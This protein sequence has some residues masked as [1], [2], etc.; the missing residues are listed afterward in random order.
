MNS[1]EKKLIKF[2][3]KSRE[4]T[5]FKKRNRI[6]D[7]VKIAPEY[8]ACSFGNKNQNKLFYVI[9]RYHGGGFFSNFLF[10]LNHLIQADKLNA[11]P[12]V[13]MENFTNVYSERK[14]INGTY[15]SWLYY[16][17]QVSPY[18]L[19]E[20]YKSKRVIFSSEKIF[21]E[22]SV[23]AKE[24]EGEL[25]KV[26]K[27]YINIKKEFLIIANKFIK[28]NFFNKKILGVHWRGTD[29]KVLPS[30][31]FPPTEKQI[32][33]ITD[34]LMSGKKF[35]MI[36]LVTEEKRYLEIFKKNYGSKVC[37]FNSFRS[38]T[39]EQFSKNS[40]TNHRY[41]LGKES[42]IE[43]L[44]LSNLSSLVC[45]RS[46]IS[47][48]AKFLSNNKKFKIYEIMNGFNSSSILHSLYMWHLKKILPKFLGGFK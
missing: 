12:V 7:K 16:F 6:F 30:H 48:Q 4:K 42:L 46:N 2:F 33:K 41:N 22:Q 21:F 36:F 14:K 31:P 47:E 1:L 43:V 3:L 26:Y 38:N 37:Y 44:I 34:K 8:K 18:T 27:K 35:N 19:V 20:V 13:D 25:K 40:R 24:N 32:L 11:I 15:N 10:V 5:F 45:S 23:S 17:E 29:H 28:K 9:K 39:R